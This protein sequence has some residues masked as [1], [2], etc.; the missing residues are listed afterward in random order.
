VEHIASIF[1][2]EEEAKNE[3]SRSREKGELFP[4]Y[5]GLQVRR[6]FSFDFN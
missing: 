1:R 2:V 6:S 3:I 4:N 5:M